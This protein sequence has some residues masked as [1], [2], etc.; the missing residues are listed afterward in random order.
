MKNTIHFKWKI[1]AFSDET[2]FIRKWLHLQDF[3]CIYKPFSSQMLSISVPYSSRSQG[4][5]LINQVFSITNEMVRSLMV[6]GLAS[7]LGVGKELLKSEATKWEGKNVDAS[8]EYTWVDDWTPGQTR[9]RT[10]WQL[11]A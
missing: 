9:P 7:V 1:T 10:R 8:W 5:P 2:H 11:P 3:F 4:N 6:L